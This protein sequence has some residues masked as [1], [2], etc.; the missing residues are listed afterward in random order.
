MTVTLKVIAD[1]VGRSVT[2]V[3]RALAGYDDVSAETREQIRQVARELG[4][5]PNTIARQ[6]QKQRTDTIALLMPPVYPRLS[7]PFFSE[8]LSGVIEQANQQGLDFLVSHIS[9]TDDPVDI[10]LK[11]IRARRVDGFILIRTIRQDPRID[12]LRDKDF[13]F[14]AFG[15]IDGDN[16]FCLIDSDDMLGVSFLV[17]HLIELGH[18]RLAFIAEPLNLT[19]AYNR[20]QGFL[21]TLKAHNIPVDE[22]MIVE[23]GYRQRFGRVVTQQLLERPDPPT[24]IVTCNDLLA[25]GAMKTAQEYG[26][27]VGRDISITGFDDILLSEYA[28]PP[29]TTI[30]LP[31]HHIGTML[32]RMLIKTINDKSLP[33]QQVIMQPDLIIRQ[34]TGSVP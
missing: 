10:Y 6:L 5:E 19:K 30:H 7:D 27:V 11:Y 23:G 16:D 2:T 20:L 31:A 24:A 18:T 34:S 9:S 15:R 21:Q 13:P 25:L 22:T 1:R 17:E 4:Y 33:K 29:L 12:L 26:L 32:C 14:A 3:S 8:F 28:H